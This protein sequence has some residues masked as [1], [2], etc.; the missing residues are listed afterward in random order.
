MS[1]GVDL[2]GLFR[3]MGDCVARLAKGAKPAETPMELATRFHLTI[4]LKSAARP[5]V[6]ESAAFAARADEGIE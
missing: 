6:S 4:N 3:D 5:G 1:Y 2:A